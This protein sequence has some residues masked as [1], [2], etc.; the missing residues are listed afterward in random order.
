MTRPKMIWVVTE[1]QTDE[2]YYKQIIRE[3]RKNNDNVPFSVDKIK[4]TCAKGIGRF[5][6]KIPNVF[7]K[8]IIKAFPEH[9]KVVF[10]CYDQDVF[11][12][13]SKPPVDRKRLE[14]TLKECGASKV[15]HIRADKTIED[16]FMKDPEGIKNH[17]RLSQN[18]RIN[19][20][21][22][23]LDMIKKMFKDA[24]RT[25]FKG[26]KTEGLIEALDLTRIMLETCPDL[27]NLC[28]ELGVKCDGKRCRK[29]IEKRQ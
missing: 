13:A 2:E 17:L 8:D 1:G 11:Q 18:Y 20:S 26:E 29:I 15:Y 12:F 21:L 27:R 23:G 24:N 5:E 19:T 7:K 6:K 10:L 3:I 9:D 14:S 4:H 25:Y 22:S 28:R 16:V